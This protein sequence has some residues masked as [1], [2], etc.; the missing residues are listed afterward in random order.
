VSPPFGRWEDEPED[1][2]NL[3]KMNIDLVHDGFVSFDYEIVS[4]QWQWQ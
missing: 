4:G 1:S 3:L 2:D